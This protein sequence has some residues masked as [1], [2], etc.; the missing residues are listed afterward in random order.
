MA[1]EARRAPSVHFLTDDAG[2]GALPAL[3]RVVR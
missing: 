2:S 1:R 3:N